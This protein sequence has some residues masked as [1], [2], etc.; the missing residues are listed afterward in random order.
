MGTPNPTWLVVI[1]LYVHPY[2]FFF[3]LWCVVW[4]T[5][6]TCVPSGCGHG[7]PPRALATMVEVQCGECW[8]HRL[9]PTG[10]WIHTVAIR[11]KKLSS[12]V[13]IWFVW[14]TS[15]RDASYESLK[16][17]HI[18]AL[19]EKCPKTDTVSTLHGICETYITY[20]RVCT[21]FPSPSNR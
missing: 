4:S 17:F 15:W 11:R 9:V 7:S 5:C 6:L 21:V 2:V 12:G 14:L 20:H 1:C 19:Y 13:D 18:L 10:R 8:L 3:M 16:W